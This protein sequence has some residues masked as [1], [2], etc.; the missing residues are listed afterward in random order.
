MVYGNKTDI[1]IDSITGDNHSLNKLNFV[2][3]DSIDVDYV[4]SIKNVWEASE[5]LYSMNSVEYRE[6]PHFWGF[7]CNTPSSGILSTQVI[8]KSAPCP[9]H[10]SAA[11]WTCALELHVTNPMS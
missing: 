5:D 7:F 10:Q 1:A 11:S 9:N 6:G 3:L 2:A 4:P 8:A